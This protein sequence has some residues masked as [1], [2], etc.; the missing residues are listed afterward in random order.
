MHAF[1]L[2]GLIPMES[3]YINHPIMEAGS[4]RRQRATP[5]P[6]TPRLLKEKMVTGFLMLCSLPVCFILIAV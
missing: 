1:G 3:P 2:L 5:V 6:V 4:V